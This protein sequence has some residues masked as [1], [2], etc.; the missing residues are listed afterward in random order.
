MGAQWHGETHHIRRAAA[1]D[2]PAVARIY[3]DILDAQD[4]GELTVGW[5]RGVYPTA[6]TAEAALGR[7]D[8]FVLE[9]DGAVLGAAVIN[10]LQV[11]VYALAPWEHE[12]AD[13]EVCVL[14]TL[15][16]SPSAARRGL[17][18]RFVRFY[19]DYARDHG[20]SELRIDTNARNARARAMYAG[21][22]Y[23]EVA[24]VPTVFNGIPNVELVLLEKNLDARAQD[25]F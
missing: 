19:E 8:L 6:A 3:E 16:I 9:E 20:M 15:V 12:A 23:R 21:L 17:G 4:A 14:H 22:G 10:R 13:G 25:A 5:A 2:L 18:K 24:I 7:G 1:E 11:D